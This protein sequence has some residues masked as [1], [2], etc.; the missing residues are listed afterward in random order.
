LNTD[1]IVLSIP[2]SKRNADGNDR[3]SPSVDGD[4]ERMSS[5]MALEGV[6]G[7]GVQ[8]AYVYVAS[9]VDVDERARSPKD[10]AWLV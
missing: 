4:D 8:G 9:G 10:T 6:T 5:G 7:M 1:K 3:R 2:R